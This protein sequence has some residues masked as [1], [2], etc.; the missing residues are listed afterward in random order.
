MVLGALSSIGISLEKD[1]SRLATRTGYKP[2]GWPPGAQTGSLI[3][4]LPT[5]PTERASLFAKEQ[6]ILVTEGEIAVVI[7][8]GSLV[9]TMEPGTYRTEKQRVLGNVD[10]IWMKTGPRLIRWGVGNVMSRDGIQ[11]GANGTVTVKIADGARFNAE[12]VQGALTL[13][14]TELQRLLMPGV[15]GILRSMLGSTEALAL[16]TERDAFI[17]SISKGLGQNLEGLGLALGAF[18]VAEFNLPAEFKDAV[19]SAT[20]ATARGKGEVVQA[21]VELQKRVLEAQGEAAAMLLAGDARAKVF[22]Q[23][24][25]AGID[26]MSV[27][28]MD[29][30]KKYAE[31][32]SVGGIMGA[33]TAKAGL[34]ASITTAAIRANQ[35]AHEA[36]QEAARTPAAAEPFTDTLGIEAHTSA[37]GS[38]DVPPPPT[39][40]GGETNG[41][42][43][44]SLTSQLDKLTE[45]L[46]EGEISEAL[47]MKL[48]ERLEQRIAALGESGG[49]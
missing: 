21:E 31:T 44:A 37:A 42:S 4:R 1:A 9:G 29:A 3:Y 47:Y 43:L 14:D 24:R 34:I 8:D 20:L 36:A 17:D 26:P 38:L 12:V 39:D 2:I 23:L 10:V 35:A 25:A 28:A 41:A 40:S 13:P 5:D 45:R 46:A 32:P 33:D 15:Q 19:S 22:A 48:S 18:E 16:M 6:R 7:K 30:L 27:E 11:V 49:D